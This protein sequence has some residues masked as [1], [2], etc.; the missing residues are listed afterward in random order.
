MISYRKPRPD[1]AEV[2]AALHVRCWQESYRGFVPDHL[3]DSAK[4]EDRIEMWRNVPINPRRVVIGAYEGDQ[5]IGFAVAGE[6]HERILEDEDG[7]LAAIYIAKSHHR[8]GIGRELVKR[9]AAEW[10]AMGGHSLSVCVLEGNT[11][12]IAFYEKM[13]AKF[14]KNDMHDWGGNKLPVRIY[15]WPDLTKIAK[16]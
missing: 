10:Q 5:A 13:A 6:P 16:I 4:A 12:A 15:L 8:L 1:E 7:Q 3:L 9:S 2:F 11:Q 14:V